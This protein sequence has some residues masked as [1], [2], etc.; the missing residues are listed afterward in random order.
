[1]EEFCNVTLVSDD[2]EIFRAHKVV[3]ASAITRFRET[4]QRGKGENE[5]QGIYLN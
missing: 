1:M 4:F 5:H 3:R 2:K